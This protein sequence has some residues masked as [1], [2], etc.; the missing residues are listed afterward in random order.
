MGDLRRKIVSFS[1]TLII[2]LN[3]ASQGSL[4]EVEM[5]MAEGGGDLKDNK[6]VC[7]SYHSA[8]NFRYQQ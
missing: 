1:S 3:L 5:Q 7:R 6:G 8:S 4:G 2:L